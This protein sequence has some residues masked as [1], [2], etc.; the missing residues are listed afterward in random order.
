M[1]RSPIPAGGNPEL[2]VEVLLRRENAA[3]QPPPTD[4]PRRRRD[5][6]ARSACRWPRPATHRSSIVGQ[7]RDDAGVEDPGTT[8]EPQLELPLRASVGNPAGIG[9]PLLASGAGHRSR[10][11][12]IRD[13]RDPPDPTAGQEA[14]WPTARWS[15]VS[16]RLAASPTGCS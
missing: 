4:A 10:R 7:R 2:G 16:L 1:G 8:M 11:D 3:A 6:S 13:G 15:S 9:P 5:D 14:S 12:P